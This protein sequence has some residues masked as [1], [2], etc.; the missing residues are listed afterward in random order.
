MPKGVMKKE[1]LLL[2]IDQGTT[3]SKAIAFNK[4]GKLVAITQRDLPQIYP[5]EA[6]VEHDPEE[7]W[8]TSLDV[9]LRTLETAEVNGD[10]VVAIGITNQRETIV[11]WDQKTG[12]PIYNAIVWQDRRTADEC[13]RLQ[14]LNLEEQVQAKTGLLLDPYFSATKVAWI[15]DHVPGSRTQAKEGSILLGTVDSFLLW[16]L[17]AGKVHATDATNAS[18]TGLYNIHSSE[19]DEGLLDLYKIP[20]G[21]LPEVHDSSYLIG[22]TDPAIFGRPIP[23][24]GIAGEQQ[25][26]TVGQCCFRRGTVKATYGTGGFILVNTGNNVIKSSNRLLSTIAYR[27]EGKPLMPSKGQFLTQVQRFNGSVTC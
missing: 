15:L 18:R 4:R 8:R 7:I 13:Y 2:S 25:V 17:T 21:C 10:R 1:S 24:S 12:I 14:E 6:W 9:A 11:L 16:R 27:I 19:W 5:A 26:A 22:E 3:T 20:A 23:I